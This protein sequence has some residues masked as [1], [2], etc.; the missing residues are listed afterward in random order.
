M[1]I[2]IAT[3]KTDGAERLLQIS[4]DAD[5]VRAATERTA[6]RY[7]SKVRLPGF[8]A[9]KAPPQMV[10]KRFAD[11]IR[12]ET[13]EHLVQEA[14]KTILERENL[15]VAAQPHIHDLKFN[16]GEPLTFDLH[17]EVR[18]EIELARV[19]GFRV[20]RTVRTVSDE[21]VQEMLDQ[22]REQR[23]TWSPTDERPK[24][25]DLVTVQLSTADDAGTMSEPQEYKIVIGSGSAIPGIEELIME[26]APGATA[27]RAVR[28]PD[29][30]PDE[31]QRGKTKTVRLTLTDVKRKQL[32]EL[33]DVG[34][35]E[36]LDA[37]R[38]VVRSDLEESAKRES[39]AEVRQKLLDE[40]IGANSFDVPKSWVNQVVHAYAELYR[41][42]NE[43]RERFASQFLPTA[44]RQVRRDLVI[45]TLAEREKLNSSERDLDDRISDMAAKRGSEP[46]KLYAQLQKADRLKELERS[47]MEDK[48]FAWLF[49]RNTID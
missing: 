6:R 3:K 35:F 19:N 42:P 37:L 10:L 41:I 45:E 17:V 46:G 36:S 47:I 27:E 49:E 12:Q 33:D 20:T 16:E 34:D 48:V 1:N 38:N 23:A 25:G 29:D 8:R 22:M 31:A 13:I 4:V 18:P 28:W 15:K 5:E 2:Q 7:A 24:E 9:G 26:T 30:F 40:I 43:E 14:Y 44:E 21:N 39:D 11:A 32:P